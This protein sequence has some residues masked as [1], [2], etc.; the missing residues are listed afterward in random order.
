[1]L[2]AAAFAFA[3]E[4]MNVS[5]QIVDK[6]NQPVPYASVS[7]S[8]KANKLFSDAT[9]TDEKGTYNVAL[10]PGNYDITIEAID[11][12]KSTLN[13]QISKPGSLGNFTVEQEG[14]LTNTKTQDIQGVTIIAQAVKPYRV[15]I[16]KKVYDPSLDIVSKGGNL[17][18]VLSN[19]PSV[20]VDTDG[21]VSMRGNTNVK[22]L[23]NGKPSS[24]LGIDDGANALQSIPADQIERIEVITNPSSKFEAS[25]TAG[26]LNIILKKDKKM[27][28]NGTVT[29]TLGYLPRT[30]LNANLNWR[31]GNWTWYLNGGGG[32]NENESSS[33]NIVTRKDDFN[34][35]NAEAFPFTQYSN[36][37]GKSERK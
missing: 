26:I 23:I 37:S 13:K 25:G 17:Q 35:L 31:K 34:T 22:F 1:M 24:L 6:Q 29:G 18:D 16:D 15:E 8:N 14:S 32:Y 2:S 10:V 21:T 11:F 28:F 4:K 3:Q 30:N 36:Q 12:K 27:G 20:T 19:V 9:L 33:K 5:G 7:F